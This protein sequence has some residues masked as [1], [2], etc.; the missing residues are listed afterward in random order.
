MAYD[1]RF[2]VAFVRANTAGWR[3]TTSVRRAASG[4]DLPVD[5]HKLIALCALCPVFISAGAVAGPVYKLL[6]KRVVTL[7]IIWRRT[8][9]TIW[10][11]GLSNGDPKISE[12]VRRRDAYHAPTTNAVLWVLSFY[13]ANRPIFSGLRVREQ[14]GQRRTYQR[15]LLGQVDWLK[16][17]GEIH[18]T[19]PASPSTRLRGLYFVYAGFCASSRTV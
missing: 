17:A 13:P 12:L 16:A 1:S 8:V 6:G 15:R 11:S 9:N 10:R 14:R 19:T 2:A 3:A 7:R 5:S 4:N 18:S